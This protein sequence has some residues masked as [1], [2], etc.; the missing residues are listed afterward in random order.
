MMHDL[1]PG[2]AFL[3]W[4]PTLA[5][6]LIMTI[7][8]ILSFLRYRLK[9]ER[10]RQCQRD[11]LE[12]AFATKRP[13]IGALSCH[14]HGHHWTELMQ[15]FSVN[16]I[17]NIMREY[18]ADHQQHFGKTY[19]I[20]SKRKLV[21]LNKFSVDFDILKEFYILET[22]EEESDRNSAGYENDVFYSPA[23][24]DI[25]PAHLDNDKYYDQLSKNLQK[26]KPQHYMGHSEISSS[27][28]I[29]KEN[30]PTQGNPY[31]DQSFSVANE[32]PRTSEKR[33]K[34]HKK[35]KILSFDT[36]RDKENDA[37]LKELK[38]PNST[39]RSPLSLSPVHFNTNQGKGNP[40]FTVDIDCLSDS[41]PHEGTLITHGINPS[42]SAG[43]ID[44][45]NLP[46]ANQ[47]YSCARKPLYDEYETQPVKAKSGTFDIV[48]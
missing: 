12:L 45:Q 3:Y 16:Q 37:G 5:I 33:H 21:F 32:K 2:K 15:S 27:E 8:L 31:Y 6:F 25:P 18:H 38:I 4:I 26:D 46:S 39:I 28:E 30:N 14:T 9:K 24:Y 17:R 42:H 36:R 44:N 34:K 47:Y 22:V 7:F 11:Y 20:S 35:K 1:Q 41:K 13:R 40:A 10:G 19:A 48:F 23:K 29:A 43:K